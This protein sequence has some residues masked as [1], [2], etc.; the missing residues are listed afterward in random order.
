[1]RKYRFGRDTSITLKTNTSFWVINRNSSRTEVAREATEYF[2]RNWQ[3]WR[4]QMSPKQHKLLQFP[5]VTHH[6]YMVGPYFLRYQTLQLSGID[7]NLKPTWS[8]PPWQTNSTIRCYASCLEEKTIGFYQAL[9]PACYNTNLQGKK[10][11]LKQ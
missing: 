1:M 4:S 11:S 5:L 3:L 8:L 9:D 2:P 10:F 6:K 7:I